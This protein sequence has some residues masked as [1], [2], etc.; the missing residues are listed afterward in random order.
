MFRSLNKVYY[1]CHAFAYSSRFIGL[2]VEPRIT[3]ES[4]LPKQA[5]YVGNHQ[6]S[7]DLFIFPS[8]F[9]KRTV[10][11]G[12]KSIVW[13]PIFGLLYWASG[14]ILI[15]RTNRKK[16]IATIDQ[17]VDQM[18]ASHLSIWMF[19]EGTRSRGRGLLPFKSGAFHAAVQ[20]GLPI[21]PVVSSDIHN[22]IKLSRWNNGKVIV[23]MLA[24]I[25]TENLSVE[26]IP[27]LMEECR[28][29]M[30]NK[31]QELTKESEEE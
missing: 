9:P 8:L 30:E 2:S 1:V 7:F 17:I 24:P 6:N 12:K 15:N 21:I 27:S 22:K 25:S 16:A 31:L 4:K 3:A 11:V 29:I 14:N 19:P 26:D 10:T 13:I 20:A 5:V 23:E 28:Q 18:K